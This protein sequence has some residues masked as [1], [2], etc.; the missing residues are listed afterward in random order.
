[1]KTKLINFFSFL[2]IFSFFFFLV[3]LSSVEAVEKRGGPGAGRTIEKSSDDAFVLEG[4]NLSIKN[5]ENEDE[6]G[7]EVPSN[8]VNPKI[9]NKGLE[10]A[11]QRRSQVSSAVQ[12][13]LKVAERSGGIG[14]QVRAMAQNQEKNQE[15]LEA[16][17]ERIQNRNKLVR[18]IF[19]PD[20][21]NIKNARKL[22]QDNKN[23]LTRLENIRSQFIDVVDQEKV[24]EQIEKIKEAS[25]Q[26]ERDLDKSEKVFS[27]F[28]WV[29]NIFSK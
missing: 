17:L 22:L 26:I 5:L 23:E 16:S 4:D 7:G 20:N 18:F 9:K 2:F 25:N 24:Q 28:G 3:S 12:E 14:E 8:L 1:M 6:G 15:K 27:L 29:K 10:N 21:Q 11:I 13:M 19:G